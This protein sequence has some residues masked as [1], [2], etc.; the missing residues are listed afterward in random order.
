MFIVGIWTLF[1][2]CEFRDRA[3]V[4]GSLLFQQCSPFSF[5]FS[6]CFM[7]SIPSWWF[8]L[9]TVHTISW[10]GSSCYIWITHAGLILSSGLVRWTFRF[11][12]LTYFLKVNLGQVISFPYLT[13]SSTLHVILPH[14]TYWVLNSLDLLFNSEL[15]Y[16]GCMMDSFQDHRF[17]EPI[18]LLMG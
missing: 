10:I 6:W 11:H 18:T 3:I 17:L 5:L 1:F 16:W 4:D 7:L 12:E 14:A 9:S 2:Q 15:L 8:P 13:V